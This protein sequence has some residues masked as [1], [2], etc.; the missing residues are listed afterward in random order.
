MNEKL[1]KILEKA[2]NDDK[3][4]KE[5]IKPIEQ[6]Y[7]MGSYCKAVTSRGYYIKKLD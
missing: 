5:L 6:R 2:K 7:V 3:F 1:T 4:R